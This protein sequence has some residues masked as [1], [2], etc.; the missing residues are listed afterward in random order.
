MEAQTEGC[1]I[2]A[3]DMITTETAG[4][5][6]RSASGSTDEIIAGVQKGFAPETVAL[7]RQYWAAGK[8]QA[9]IARAA[10]VSIDTVKKITPIFSKGGKP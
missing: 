6:G 8:K 5:A 1:E 9:E 4:S 2:S 10:K 3:W 7:V